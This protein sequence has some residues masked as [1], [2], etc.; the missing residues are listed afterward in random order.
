MTSNHVFERAEKQRG[1]R[2]AAASVI[3]AGPST[4]R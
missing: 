1:P 2:L 4:G 3:V